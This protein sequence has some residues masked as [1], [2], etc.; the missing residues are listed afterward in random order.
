MGVPQLASGSRQTRLNGR[1]GDRRNG[2]GTNRSER[3]TAKAQA[4]KYT[5][6]E[7]KDA[8]NQKLDATKTLFSKYCE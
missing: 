3:E 6:L 1:D 5:E 2:G 8:A 4:S 7:A